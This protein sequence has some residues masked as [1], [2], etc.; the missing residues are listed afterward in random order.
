MYF[1][2]HDLQP[3]PNSPSLSHYPTPLLVPPSKNILNPTNG[4]L[5]KLHKK[6][7]N[8]VRILFSATVKYIKNV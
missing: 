2:I 8:E 1:F 3:F 7:T 5:N 4:H 6:P